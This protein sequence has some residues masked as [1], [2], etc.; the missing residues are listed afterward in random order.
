MR[1]GKITTLILAAAVV[2]G[3]SA[4]WL[5][6]WYID[7]RVRS[8]RAR[9]DKELEPVKV[10]VAVNDMESGEPMTSANVAVRPIP[11]AFVPRDAVLPDQ[12]GDVD[13][14]RL[15]IPVNRGEP[16]LY[17]YLSKGA[18]QPFSNV[19]RVG[20]RALTVRVDEVSSQSGMLTP[21]DRVDVIAT[22]SSVGGSLTIPLLRNVTILATGAKSASESGGYPGPNSPFHTVT[23]ALT[24]RDAA[25]VTHAREIGKLTV[26]LRSPGD[27]GD[28]KF[29]TV[30]KKSLLGLARRRRTHVAEIILGGK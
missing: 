9:L 20:E 28:G 1:K 15:A 7:S 26:V 14:R 11:R 30:T 16:I 23:M 24:P 13:G 17:P 8:Y 27:S 5:T 10:V 4:A 18:G 21:G 22:L 3:L 12:Y 6:H 2:C 29:A 19:I 25:R